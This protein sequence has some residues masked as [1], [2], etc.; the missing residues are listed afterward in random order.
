VPAVSI[1][2]GF[3]QGLPVGLQIV[4][5]HF[6]EAKLLNVAHQ[7]QRETDWHARLPEAYA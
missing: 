6:S 2:C 5:P 1:P 4:G 7:Y 3:V